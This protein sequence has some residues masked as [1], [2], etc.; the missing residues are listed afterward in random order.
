MHRCHTW[1][2]AMWPRAS[3]S[4]SSLG[5]SLGCKRGTPSTYHRPVSQLRW[6][7]AL[8]NPCNSLG[9][10][11]TQRCQR[12]GIPVL[13]IPRLHTPYFAQLAQHFG[14]CPPGL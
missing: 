7:P 2:P 4:Q 3:K 10:P 5:G 12:G 9:P 14:W 8:F 6:Y 13:V 11:D 1:T